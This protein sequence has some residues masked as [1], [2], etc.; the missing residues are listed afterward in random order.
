MF[1]MCTHVRSLGCQNAHAQ[2]NLP[3]LLDFNLNVCFPWAY[4]ASYS[5][6]V[7]DHKMIHHKS[8]RAGE[9]F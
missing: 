3:S 8:C 1:K 4:N 5:L 6:E 2:I 9:S 7:T